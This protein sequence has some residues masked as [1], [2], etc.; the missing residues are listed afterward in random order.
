GAVIFMTIINLRGVRESG[1]VFSVPTYV[2][3]IAMFS[4]LAF[5]IW[6]GVIR[7]L[8]TV[9]LETTTLPVLSQQ[10]TTFL[11]LRAFAAGCTA[12]TGVEAISNGIPAFEPNG[13]H[14]PGRPRIA[15]VLFLGSL[16]GGFPLIAPQTPATPAETE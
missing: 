10:I 9:Q 1:T 13:S 6:K 16:F 12:L 15:M 11:I 8:S 14:N 7:S 4:L 3:I 5:G 2:F